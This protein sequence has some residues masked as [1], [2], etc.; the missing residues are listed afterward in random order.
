MAYRQQKDP[1]SSKFKIDDKTL[2]FTT[3]EKK[4]EQTVCH[5]YL[6]FEK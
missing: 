3:Q 4:K 5:N 2:Y 1:M 6:D